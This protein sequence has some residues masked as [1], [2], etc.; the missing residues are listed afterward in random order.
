[1]GSHGPTWKPCS[2]STM[3]GKYFL[4]FV[5][6]VVLSAGD[7]DYELS[8]DPYAYQVKVEDDKTS[9]RYEINE[10]GSPEIVEGSYR[11]ALPDGRV[12]VVTYQVHADKGFEAK[13][14]QVQKTVPTK[15]CKEENWT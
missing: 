8:R 10:S 1:M 2:D 7:D 6:Q 5:C 9:N 3:R 13:V 12:Q 4:L 14:R 11:I 15:V